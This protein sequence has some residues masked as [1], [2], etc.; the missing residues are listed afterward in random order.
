MPTVTLTDI[1]SI[2]TALGAS[3]SQAATLLGVST[4][5]VQSC[6]PLSIAVLLALAT[7]TTAGTALA[8]ND[9]TGP[10]IERRV[11]VDAA[12][13]SLLQAEEATVAAAQLGKQDVTRFLLFHVPVDWHHGE[14]DYPIGWPRCALMMGKDAQDWQR[15]DRLHFRVLTRSSRQA[16]PET[17]L[18][19]YTDSGGRTESWTQALKTLRIGQWVD[20]DFPVA[21]IPHRQQVTKLA[22]FVSESSY[23]D[24]DNVDFFFSPIELL[25]YTAPT[26]TAMDS[27]AIAFADEP[28][29][30]LTV[31][32]LGVDAKTAEVRIELRNRERVILSESRSV[33]A[34]KTRLSLALPGQ[35]APGEYQI[36]AKAG[37]KEFVSKL[38]LV[39]SPWK[40]GSR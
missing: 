33:P 39:P 2:R 8:Q 5:A 28:T 15:W 31:E 23:R 21:A 19:I 22:L 27:V 6:G 25:R 34:G 30:P 9:Q 11:L 16:L 32:M 12:H 4:K 14:P 26:L 3:Q 24:G 36:A 40:E 38:T 17:P 7:L 18:T 1:R 35:T 10:G 29:L 20:F 37:E 13:A